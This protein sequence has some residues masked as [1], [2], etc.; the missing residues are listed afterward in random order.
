MHNA[1]NTSLL[2]LHSFTE[3]A[4]GSGRPPDL[5]TTRCLLSLIAVIFR[6]IAAGEI[7]AVAAQGFSGVLV[8]A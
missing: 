4:R 6:A 7:L 1:F 2:P 5:A 3:A 8:K